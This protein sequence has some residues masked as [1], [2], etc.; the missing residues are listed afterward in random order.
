MPQKYFKKGNFSGSSNFGW[1][2]RTSAP[3]TSVWSH[4]RL[5]LASTK[6][7]RHRFLSNQGAFM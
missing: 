1:V 3:S 6:R 4:N 7:N 2:A 5:P